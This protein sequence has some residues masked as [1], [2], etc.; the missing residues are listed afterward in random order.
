MLDSNEQSQVN[1]NFPDAEL[2]VSGIYNMKVF[3]TNHQE[4]ARGEISGG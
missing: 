3:L 2:N 1:D 4:R